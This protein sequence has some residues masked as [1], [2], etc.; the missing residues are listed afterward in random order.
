MT[1]EEATQL[2]ISIA[3]HLKEVEREGHFLVNTDGGRYSEKYDVSDRSKDNKKPITQVY[4]DLHVMHIQTLARTVT[5][6]K[7]HLGSS[8][9]GTWLNERHANNFW[10]ENSQA[11]VVNGSNQT[12]LHS[13]ATSGQLPCP[14]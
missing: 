3:K 11:H 6:T 4:L 14:C 8:S 5:P 9:S 2:Y 1:K 10:R 12:R 13:E 7:L